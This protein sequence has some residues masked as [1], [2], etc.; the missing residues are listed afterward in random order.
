MRF[1]DG[2]IG[3]VLI[4]FGAAVLFYTQGFP[5]LEEGYPGPALFPGVLAVL[6]LIAGLVLLIQGF[7]SKAALIKIDR[8]ALGGRALLNIL[9]VHGA[10]V[11]YIFLSE[12]LGFLILSFG[13]LFLLM[14]WFRASALW[15]MV[16]ACSVTL[17]IYLLF[18]KF[19]LVPLPW[20]LW[21]W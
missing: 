20:G 6:F 1:N 14:T 15:S 16:M 3:I 2:A 19:L 11:V 21:G 9:S 5:N 17:G 7:R 8:E 10:V 18:A 12:P 4:L 13:L